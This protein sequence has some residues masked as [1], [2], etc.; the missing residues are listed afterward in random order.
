MMGLDRRVIVQDDVRFRRLLD[1]GIILRQEVGEVT[2]V[3]EVGVLILELIESGKNLYDIFES[4]K[5]EYDVENDQLCRDI[6]KYID[7]LAQAGIIKL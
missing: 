3:N 2:V 6:L 1:E 5:D 7:S 4:L